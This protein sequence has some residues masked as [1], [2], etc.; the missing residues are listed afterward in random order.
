MRHRLIIGGVVVVHLLEE[1]GELL[2]GQVM[3]NF[4][5]LSEEEALLL[6]VQLQVPE[7]LEAAEDQEQ[8]E[9]ADVKIRPE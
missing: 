5:L 1:G 9:K 2:V 8:G 3:T 6:P 7:H 4:E